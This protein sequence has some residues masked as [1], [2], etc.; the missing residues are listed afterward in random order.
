[1][2]IDHFDIDVNTF[3]VGLITLESND[4]LERDRIVAMP[5][6]NVSTSTVNTSY[7]VGVAQSHIS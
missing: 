6:A 5:V 7:E 3:T 4:F 2:T 1:M